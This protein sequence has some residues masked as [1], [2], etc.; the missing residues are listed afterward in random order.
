VLQLLSSQNLIAVLHRDL[1][2]Y[3]SLLL[4]E[5][6]RRKLEEAC[7]K[8]GVAVPHAGPPP[9]IHAPA[10]C[11]VLRA[12]RVSEG[13][14]FLHHAGYFA[15]GNAARRVEANLPNPNAGAVRLLN[16]A[17]AAC[18]EIGIE[19]KAASAAR[20]EMAFVARQALDRAVTAYAHGFVKGAAT[21]L[22][23][24]SPATIREATSEGGKVWSASI[25]WGSAGGGARGAPTRAGRRARR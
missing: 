1:W 15:G 9:P 6:A 21:R 2:T 19:G 7:R 18:P 4:A 14:A 8:V 17:A 13:D 5:D 11:S 20:F 25:D 12:A 24:G 23:E 10:F 3:A 16:E 22:N